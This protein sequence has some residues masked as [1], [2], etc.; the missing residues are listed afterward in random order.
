MKRRL[1]GIALGLWIGGGLAL[2][3]TALILY[4]GPEG[5]SEA[6]VTGRFVSFLLGHFQLDSVRLQPL[7][8]CRPREAASVDFLFVVVEEGRE[9]LP[10]AL[11]R[12]IASRQAPLVWINLQLEELLREAPRRFPLQAAGE[13]GARG[14]R[15]YFQQQEFS[16][17][18]GERVVL[19][20]ASS[21]CQVLAW[22]E[23][24][25]GRSLPYAVRAG[26]LWAFADSPF[27]WSREGGRWLI[28]G[29]LLHDILGQ[30]HTHSRHALLRIE[31]VNPESDPV[32]IRRITNFLAG[33]G[34]PFQISLIPVYRDPIAQREV[35]LSANL[36]LVE[37][38][39]E[40]ARRGAAIV[41]HGVTH[42]YRGASGEDYELWD[43]ISGSPL[44]HA[45]R[46][47]LESRLLRG[48]DEICRC[49]LYPI[50][51]ETPHY[52]AAQRDYR[53]ISRFFDTLYDRPMVADLADT[54]MLA[55]YPYR[56][57]DTGPRVI[58]ENLGY[59]DQKRRRED[60][61]ALLASLDR[62]NAVRDALAS[63]FFHPFLPLADLQRLVGEF[64]RRGWKFVSLRE[65]GGNLRTNSRWVSAS[66]GPGRIVLLNQHLREQTFAASG[67]RLDVSVTAERY[68]GVVRRSVNLPRNGLY[69]AE[70]LDRITA[71]HLSAWARLKRRIASMLRRRPKPPLTL[72]RTLLLIGVDVSAAE[73]NDQRSFATQLRIFGFKPDEF[74]VSARPGL[75]LAGV[76]LLVVPQA[77]A[78]RL[79]ASGIAEVVEFAKRGGRVVTDGHSELAKRLGVRFGGGHWTA[80]RVRDLFLPLPGFEWN[81]P[82]AVPVFRLTGGEALC[83]DDASGLPVAMAGSLGSGRVLYLGALFDPH[84]TFGISRFPHFAYYLKNAMGVPFPVRRANL[85]F[86]FDP[87]L[88]QG[89]A[90]EK[91]VRRW[92]DSGV[93]IVYLAAWHDYPRYRFDYKYFIDLCH[94]HGISVYA[95]FEFPQVTPRLWAEHPEWRE[96]TSSGSDARIGWR[97]QMNLLAVSARD[98]AREY[99]RG[100]LMRH[101]WDGVNLAELSWDTNHGLADPANFVPMSDDVRRVFARQAGFDPEELF[102]PGSRRHFLRDRVALDRF[103]RFRSDL[104]LELHEIFLGD[105]AA[106][107]AAKNRPM[108]IIVTVLDSLLNP[109]VYEWCGIDSAA[110]AGLTKRHRFTLQVE[111]PSSTW[112]DPPDRYDAYMRAYRPL[113]DDPAR[114]MFD[115]NVVDR[116]GSASR[117]L[118]AARPIGGELC[119][120]FFHAAQASGRVGIYAESTVHPF[121][122]DLLPFVQGGDVS[123]RPV[124]GGFQVEAH[125]PFAL[126]LE[127]AGWVPLLDDRQW[128]FHDGSRVIL[129]SGRHHLSFAEAGL[130]DRGGISTRLGFNGDIDELV[131][132]GHVFRFGYDSLTPV[133]LSFNRPLERVTLDGHELAVAPDRNMLMLAGGRHRIEIVTASPPAMAIEAVGY[134][135]ASLFALLGLA[136]VLLLLGLYLVARWTR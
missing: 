78:R 130:L 5:R 84:S 61:D 64:Q 16:A 35:F 62:M 116:P 90:W 34:I 29:E 58:P 73:Q 114:L 1:A 89:V 25:D 69:V 49:G 24:D 20:P 95:W 54:Q 30:P 111:D 107:I 13:T 60:G 127:Q 12:G 118:P 31:D 40:A 113:L 77:A 124:A 53:V 55:P 131:A 46:D 96:K 106:V 88:R 109:A 133:S 117:H 51:W 87:G 99:F 4:D 14:W 21:Q 82:A 36:P 44:A 72:P 80:A 94:A 8:D 47:W 66:G 68:S 43:P 126:M 115:I 42:Q 121:D 3:Q 63:F 57:S 98:A 136:A 67:R 23:A 70:A 81:P 52:A 38:L 56:L 102:R 19:R 59:I 9:P 120:T 2:G 6:Y 132:D 7:A 110:V 123:I 76:T 79:S 97:Y 119:A 71:T 41:M 50:A 85:E 86:Y 22:A 108:E 93:K 15:I 125:Q 37:A 18:A 48:I 28:L 103:L 39:R 104:L 122:M 101:D 105:A 45:G 128:P 129:P 33:E 134:V 17:E 10:R 27:S 26:N 100:L 75:P 65:Y 112:L 91:L 74:I 135:S 11:L 32:A 83:T 92:R